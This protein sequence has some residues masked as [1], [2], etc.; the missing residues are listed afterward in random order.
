MTVGP[1]YI[2]SRLNH[3]ENK[4]DQ[5]III[6]PGEKKLPGSHKVHLPDFVNDSLVHVS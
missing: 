6:L 3:P 5:Q 2:S 4:I 1:L